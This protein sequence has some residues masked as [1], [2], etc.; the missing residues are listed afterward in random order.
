MKASAPFRAG[1]ALQS[2]MGSPPHPASGRHQGRVWASAVRRPAQ[3]QS[4]KTFWRFKEKFADDQAFDKILFYSYK[5]QNGPF[6]GLP[7]RSSG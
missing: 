3:P 7:W 6:P 4:W 5:D 1:P 2:F